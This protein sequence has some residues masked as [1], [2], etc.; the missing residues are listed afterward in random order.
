MA[1]PPCIALKIGGL[2]CFCFYE[3]SQVNAAE[4]EVSCFDCPEHRQLNSS[5]LRTGRGVLKP[6]SCSFD[7]VGDSKALR[8]DVQ[9]LIPGDASPQRCANPEVDAASPQRCVDPEVVVAEGELL[10]NSI[11]N[12]VVVDDANRDDT[13]QA[14]IGVSFT[15]RWLLVRIDGDMDGFLKEIGIGY[16]VRSAVAAVGYGVGK[17]TNAI[18]HEGD[19]ITIISWSPRGTFTNALIL[20]G[21]ER[22][23]VD[24]VEGRP[25]LA[26]ASWEKGRQAIYIQGV[27]C[28]T[29][30]R[31]PSSRRYFHGEEMCVEQVSPS[32]GIVR[33][34]FARQ[35]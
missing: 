32:G 31:M 23:T 6:L 8:A 21:V 26:T 2:S 35:T 16:L 11:S 33:R 9:P 14:C 22:P 4:Q 20:D 17:M 28:Q 5:P 1:V 12:G 15:G 13:T 27:L 24:P 18:T 10:E 29:G 3:P 30:Q 34:I 19:R 25:M 7:K